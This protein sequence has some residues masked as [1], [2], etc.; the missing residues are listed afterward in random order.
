MTAVA[1]CTA[2]PLSD[3]WHAAR[4]QGIGGSE[5]GTLLGYNPWATPVDL[6]LTKTGR[7]PGFTG[8]FA[9]RR[10]QHMESFLISEYE[11]AHPGTF[12]ET[13]ADG[14]PSIFAVADGSVVRCSLDGI[15]HDRDGDHLIEVKTASGRQAVKWDGGA[16]P[17]SYTAQVVWQLGV[18]G[19]D[20]AVVVADVAGDFTERTVEADRPLFED[21]AAYALDWWERHV[22]ARVMPDPDPVRDAPKL[23]RL[24]TPDPGRSVELDPELVARLRDA[25]ARAAAAKTDLEQVIAAVQMQMESAVTGCCGDEVV[26]RWSPV[27][28]RTTIDT[29]LLREAF[30]EVAAQVIRQG[31]PSRRFTVTK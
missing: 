14:M 30:P 20:R 21:M 2:P 10:G 12:V 3:D 22:E 6:W 11:H 1:V 27:V 26:A 19:L 5:I 29:G 24:W 23:P 28:G 17:E 9:T 7:E 16:L 8:N 4:A 31:P 25:K 18:M 13:T 15:A